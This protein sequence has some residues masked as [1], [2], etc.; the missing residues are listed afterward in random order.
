M[1]ETLELIGR[2]ALANSPRDAL[3]LCSAS[4]SLR[5]RLEALR[6]LAAARRLRWLPELSAYHEIT[7]AARTLT[8][9][10][11]RHDEIEPWVAG[12]LLPTEGR[13]RWRVRVERSTRNDGNGMWIGVCDAAATCSWSRPRAAR[14]ARARP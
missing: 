3:R 10:N 8:V 4:R 1:D 5:A 13:S 11:H 7:N 12:G 2:S 14:T 6:A 9:L